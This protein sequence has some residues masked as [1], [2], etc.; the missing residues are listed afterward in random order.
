MAMGSGGGSRGYAAA[1]ELD[2]MLLTPNVNLGRIDYYEGRYD[3]AYRTIQANSGM[4]DKLS[5]THLR[6]GMA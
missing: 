6:L 3:K 1:L 4:D 5:R 2:P